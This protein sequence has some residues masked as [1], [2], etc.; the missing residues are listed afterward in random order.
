LPSPAR[1]H[2]H[3]GE[4]KPCPYDTLAQE[5]SGE[6]KPSLLRYSPAKAENQKAVHMLSEQMNNEQLTTCVRQQPDTAIYLPYHTPRQERA[7]KALTLLLGPE[8]D[9]EIRL[10]AARQFAR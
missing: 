1:V 9:Y 8:T 4:D 7:L 3:A 5:A 6:D 10:R 2:L